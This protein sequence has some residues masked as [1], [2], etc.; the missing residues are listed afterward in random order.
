MLG[1]IF[2]RLSERKRRIAPGFVPVEA[3]LGSSVGQATDG[4]TGGFLVRVRKVL[5][6]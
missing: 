2:A 4:K 5:K 3:I 6:H 1:I